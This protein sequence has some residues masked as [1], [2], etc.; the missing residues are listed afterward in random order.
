MP[1]GDEGPGDEGNM[2]PA[3]S[4]SLVAAEGVRVPGN[5]VEHPEAGTGT[6]SGSSAPAGVKPS[7]NTSP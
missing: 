3:A 4:T 6:C 1:P 7:I 2:G 5:A